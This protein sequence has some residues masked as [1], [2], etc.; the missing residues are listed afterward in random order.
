M[1]FINRIEVRVSDLDLQGHVTGAAYHHY[2]DHSR[3]ACVQAAEISAEEMIAAGFGPVNLETVLRFQLLDQTT[4]RLVAD[5]ARQWRAGPN[6]CG[7][8]GTDARIKVGAITPVDLL[9]PAGLPI[10]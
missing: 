1:A 9:C 5:P 6:C 8:S 7:L 2:V 10:A 3:F 4:R